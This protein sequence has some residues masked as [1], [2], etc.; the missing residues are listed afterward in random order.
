MAGDKLEH[1][2]RHITSEVSSRKQVDTV[3]GVCEY[4][5]NVLLAHVFT[6]TLKTLGF[7]LANAYDVL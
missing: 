3:H 7:V 2:I 5:A 1:V 4:A 6:H